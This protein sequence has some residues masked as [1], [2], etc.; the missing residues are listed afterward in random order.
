MGNWYNQADRSHQNWTG[1]VPRTSRFGGS[2]Y[3][4]PRDKDRITPFRLAMGIF[5]LVIFISI[6]PAL[7]WISKHTDSAYKQ[8][9]EQRK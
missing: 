4:S 2:F 1:Q 6:I 9:E 8:T 5:V 3:E 7:N